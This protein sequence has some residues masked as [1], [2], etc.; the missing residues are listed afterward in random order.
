MVTKINAG[1]AEFEETMTCTLDTQLKS[2]TTRVEQQGQQL[3]EKTQH[4]RQ[5]FNKELQATR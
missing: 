3:R 5:E 2:V 1:Q 4:L